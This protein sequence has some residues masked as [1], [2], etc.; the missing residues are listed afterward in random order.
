MDHF[1]PAGKAPVARVVNGSDSA[2]L[3]GQSMPWLEFGL[4]ELG[5]RVVA[6]RGT[7]P[8]K[9]SD[10]VED[11][12]RNKKLSE[13]QFSE[14]CA[15]LLDRRLAPLPGARSAPGAAPEALPG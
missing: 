14:V 1:F 10:V 8:T 6:V 5:K 7:D 3:A 12:C 9:I 11:I 13:H 4:P 15:D 2:E